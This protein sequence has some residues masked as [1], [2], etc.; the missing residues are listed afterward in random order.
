MTYL[1]KNDRQ[2]IVDTLTVLAVLEASGQ[3]PEDYKHI[4]DR[5]LKFYS[6]AVAAAVIAKTKARQSMRNTRARRK[7][8][9]T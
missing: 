6:R 4:V 3:L 9:S 7:G 2:L 1:T 8:V 5:L